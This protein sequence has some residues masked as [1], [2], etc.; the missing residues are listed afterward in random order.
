MEFGLAAREQETRL[1]GIVMPA[2]VLHVSYLGG[3]G[4]GET[5]WLSQ[6]RALSR[7]VWEPYVLC[8]TPGAF[9]DELRA[10]AIHV[11]IVPYRLPYF[12]YGWLPTGTPM[13]MPRVWRYLRA[14]RI[15]LVHV[16]DPE[17]AFYVAPVARSLNL[18]VIWTCSAWWHAERGWKSQFYER[19]F[20]RI[21]CYTD[22]TKRALVAANPRLEHKIAV[23]PP[24][25]D[26]HEFAPGARDEKLLDE[27]RIARD[28]PIVTL[29][30]RFQ[31]V[32]GHEYF[33]RAAQNI[34][35]TFPA[36]RF[37]LIGDNPF[38][39]GDADAYQRAML[40]LIQ[41][42]ARLRAAVV[43][44]GFRRDIP[45]ILRAT[46]VLVCPSFF[47]TYGMAN[48][49]AMACGIPVVSTNVGGPTETI[50]DGETGFLV[51]P[52]D[53][54]A[55]AARVCALLGDAARR[56]L[57]GANA[58]RRVEQYYTLTES[59]ARLDELYRAVLQSKSE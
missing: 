19:F 48:L 18:P 44:A 16:K 23:M 45:R 43:V 8:G 53:A 58:R 29:L 51:P 31:E 47:E 38:A 2:R 10:A 57:M 41:N 39:M 11:D 42:D 24:G 7:D 28:A 22:I 14:E 6:L 5:I 49:E 36:A 20:A 54:D 1:G 4:G 15:A 59:V 9:V 40:N 35:D 27:W 50:V 13:V 33:L 30:A 21:I 26:V 46:D 52:R 56:K 12:K 55:I 37:L 32:K 17:S 3:L 34:L 25:V